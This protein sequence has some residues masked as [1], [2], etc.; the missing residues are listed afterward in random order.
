MQQEAPESIMRGGSSLFPGLAKKEI[1]Q[2]ERMHDTAILV[3][4][5]VQHL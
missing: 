5:V 3:K 4:Q 2:R 1:A